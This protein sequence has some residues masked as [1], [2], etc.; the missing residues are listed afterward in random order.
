MELKNIA[1]IQRFQV[2]VPLQYAFPPSTG[3]GQE[4][5]TE[6]GF[7]LRYRGEFITRSDRA[8]PG[9]SG[10]PSFM[11]GCHQTNKKKVSRGR[12]PH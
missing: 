11:K 3:S 6:T 12:L 8:C 5:I 2:P 4:Y 1:N 7:D 10:G 9:F